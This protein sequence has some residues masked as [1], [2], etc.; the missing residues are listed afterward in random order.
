MRNWKAEYWLILLTAAFVAF[1]GGFFAG[2]ST[3]ARGEQTVMVSTQF[4]PS[5][6]DVQTAAQPEA[7]NKTSN[8]SAQKPEAS[9]PVDLNSADKETLMTLPG[10]G[11]ALA[12]RIVEYRESFGGFES[13]E[14]LTQ[15][16]GIGS[17][18]LDA[19]REL[20]TVR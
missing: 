10:I 12:G 17:G 16:S 18:K 3:W 19:I 14:E 9:G 4:P 2:R 5:A 6:P 15:V 13:V 11:E 8:A 20:I 7:A 1:T